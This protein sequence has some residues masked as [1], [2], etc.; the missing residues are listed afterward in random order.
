MI[1]ATHLN[2]YASRVNWQRVPYNGNP[3]N[4]HALVF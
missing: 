1:T 4:K 2:K 3:M